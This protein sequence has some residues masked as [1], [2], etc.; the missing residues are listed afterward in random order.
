LDDADVGTCRLLTPVNSRGWSGDG[1]VR[2]LRPGKLQARATI[3]FA[4]SS[5]GKCSQMGRGSR[6]AGLGNVENSWRDW[7]SWSLCI[8]LLPRRLA[9]TPFRVLWTAGVLVWYQVHPKLHNAQHL[10]F[11]GVCQA[12]ASKAQPRARMRRKLFVVY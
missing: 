1:T 4:G 9:I 10:P 12:Q 11:R 6:A 2:A 7:S 5:E 3:Q 8:Y